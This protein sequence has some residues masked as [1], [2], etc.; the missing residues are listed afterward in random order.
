MKI[1]Y[2]DID[3]QEVFTSCAMCSKDLVIPMKN[4]DQEQ[5]EQLI[6][7]ELNPLVV[8]LEC[9]EAEE[10]EVKY[11]KDDLYPGVLFLERVLRKWGMWGPDEKEMRELLQELKEE[12][13]EI[14]RT[15]AHKI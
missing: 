11:I 9:S 14:I 13:F 5:Q 3:K 12:G 7:G 2:T 10:A 8:C 15:R 1:G 4:F 6:K